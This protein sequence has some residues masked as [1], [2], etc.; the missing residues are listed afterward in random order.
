MTKLRQK[1]L[2]VRVSVVIGALSVVLIILQIGGAFSQVEHLVPATRDFVRGE[3]AAF[4]EDHDQRVV[5]SQ[6]AMADQY[7]FTSSKLNTLEDLII[8]NTLTNLQKE[9]VELDT[10]LKTT[11]NDF[12]IGT[13]RRAVSSQIRNLEN[14][15]LEEDDP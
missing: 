9:L 10:R 13:R 14:R 8:G 5:T 11:P 12:L 2:T 6:L 4:R 15:L 3:V 7:R 1:Q